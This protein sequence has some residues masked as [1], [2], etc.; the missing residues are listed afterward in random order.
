MSRA[1][2]FIFKAKHKTFHVKRAWVE[3][4]NSAEKQST[5]A[6]ID[7]AKQIYTVNLVVHSFPTLHI[8]HTLSKSKTSLN[9]LIMVCQH[10]KMK[11]EYI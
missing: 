6:S 1:F 3:L 10:Y 8:K 9:V 7:L 4:E 2:P 5:Q 11:F